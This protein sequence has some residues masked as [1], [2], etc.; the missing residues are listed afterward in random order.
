[1]IKRALISVSDK[2]GLVE[3]GKALKHFQVEIISTGGTAEALQEAGI[4]TLSVSDYTGFP[5]MM[6]GRLKTL[7]PRVHGALLGRR[8]DA[9]HQEDAKTYGIQWIDLVVVNLYPFE[10]AFTRSKK[11]D[12]R[13]LVENIDIGGP[14]MIRAAAKNHEYCT[15]VVQPKDYKKIIQR[16]KKSPEEPFDF[17]FRYDMALKAFHYTGLYDSYIAQSLSS[18]EAESPS[19]LRQRDFPKYHF[20]AGQLHQEL[21]YGENP[22][23]KAAAYR[24]VRPRESL[25]VSSSLQGKELSFNNFLDADAAWRL[26][27]ELPPKSTVILKH[28]N[29]CGVGVGEG[30]KQSFTRAFEADQESAFG[31][32]VGISGEINSELAEQIAESFFEIVCAEAF[33]VGAREIFEKRKNLRLLLLPKLSDSNDSLSVNTDLRKLSGLYLLQEM[34]HLGP[35]GENNLGPDLH[36]VTKREPTGDELSSLRLSWV[37]SKHLKSNAVVIGDLFQSLGIGCGEVNRKY[38][39]QGAIDRMMS[40]PQLGSLRVCASDGFFPFR[41]SVDLLSKAGVTAIIQPGGSLRDKEVIEACDEAQMSM[42]FTKTRHFR[43]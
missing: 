35:Y 4:A 20:V 13:D 8:E 40:R 39:T 23:Q 6:E 41:D 18:Y 37:I 36:C 21:R 33:S 26:L 32:V 12:W 31:G 29:A 15:V 17:K 38:A 19:E 28:N 34:D 25:P 7:H 43:H 9:Q 5:E 11:P 3:L 1:M 30:E 27:T 16:L 2:T 24:V 14:A 10:E 42:L 22:H